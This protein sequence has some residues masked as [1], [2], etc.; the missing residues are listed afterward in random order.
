[1]HLKLGV[2]ESSNDF[3]IIRYALELV[4]RDL[5]HQI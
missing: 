1:M 4:L 3:S 5:I 2:H